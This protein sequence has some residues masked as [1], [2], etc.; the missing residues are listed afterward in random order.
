[1]RTR[2]IGTLAALLLAPAGAWTPADAPLALAPQSRLWIDGTSTV[3]A[4]QCKATVLE[5]DIDAA[6]NAVAGV[7]GGEK[8]VKSVEF[9]VPAERLE[10]GNGT[11][12]EHMFK[13]IKAKEF[14]TITFRVDSYDVAKGGD[15]VRGTLNGTLTLGGAERKIAVEAAAADAGAGAGALRVSG[16]YQ[17][18]LSEYGLKA[19][20]L[21]FGTMKVGDAVKVGFDLVLKGD[22]KVAA[23]N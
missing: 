2:L 13:A 8:A 1:M 12:N 23:T 21:M 17:L 10:C 22:V 20:T 16:A 9:R 5:A 11:M 18:R 14:K 4:F 6:P 19:P 3:R 7:L 15:G